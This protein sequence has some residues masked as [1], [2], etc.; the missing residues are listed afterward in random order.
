MKSFLL[1]L[2]LMSL[3]VKHQVEAAKFLKPGVVDPCQVPGNK[4]PGCHPEP[5]KPRQEANPYTR[6]CSPVNKC[7]SQPPNKKLVR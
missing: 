2:A 1:C 3:M 5:T 4:N 7:R 6:G